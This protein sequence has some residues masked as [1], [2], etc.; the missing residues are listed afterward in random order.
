VV[1]LNKYNN[2][3]KLYQQRNL[4]IEIATVSIKVIRAVVL[5]FAYAVLNI[6]LIIFFIGY[7]FKKIM[8]VMDTGVQRLK[9]ISKI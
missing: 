2:V 3:I 6:F 9:V 4:Q 1:C 5:N 8:D 7:T